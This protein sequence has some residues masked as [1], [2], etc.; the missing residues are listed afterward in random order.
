MKLQP[1][2]RYIQTGL[3]W[4]PLA[5]ETW[6]LFKVGRDADFSIGWT[7]PSDDDSN[8]GDDCP[9]VCIGDLSS[10]YLVTT[11][12]G[13]SAKAMLQKG[14]T[15]LPIGTLL[16]SFKLTVGA[17]AFLSVPAVT[18]EAVAA[19]RP[20]AKIAPEFLYYAAPN[21]I[22]RYGRENI[23]GSLLLNDELIRSARTFVPHLD[24][25]LRI[26]AFLDRETARIDAL[27]EKKTRFIELLREKRQALITHAVTRGLDSNASFT[28]SGVDW[29]GAIPWQ[30]RVSPLKYLVSFQSGGTPSKDERAFWDGAIPWASA[31]DLKVDRLEDTQDHLTQHALDAGAASLVPAES[32]LVVVRG[33]I[34]ARTF[35]V[36]IAATPMAINQDLKALVATDRLN[37]GFLAYLLRGTASLSLARLEEAAHGTKAL[38]MEAWTDIKLPVPPLHEQVEIVKRLDAGLRGLEDIAGKTMQTIDLLR[39]RRAALITAAVTGQIDVRAEQPDSTLEPT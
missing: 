15:R 4:L 18:N 19:F 37:A 30:W 35:P 3:K 32:V 28:D 25:Q 1:Y 10:K 16:F 24:D 26:G 36:T 8:Y 23:Y 17:V 27:I 33:M 9:W 31:K 5:P 12:K 22:P 20:S 21:F 14:A 38:R 13:L 2:P 7:P 39:E 34:L 29:L 11:S 6:K